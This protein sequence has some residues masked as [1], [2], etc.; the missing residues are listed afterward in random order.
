[1]F[2]ATF[3]ENFLGQKYDIYNNKIV[4]TK[5]FFIFAKFLY[6]AI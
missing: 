2:P 6:P 1:M 4:G 5:F 3:F